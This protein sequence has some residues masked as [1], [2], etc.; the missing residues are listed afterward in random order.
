M[1][2]SFSTLHSAGLALIL[3]GAVAAVHEVVAELL[4]APPAVAPGDDFFAYANREWLAGA[5]LPTGKGRWGARDEIAEATRQQVQ[6]V[7][8][9]SG[10]SP[11]AIRVADFH[12]AWQDEAAIEAKGAAA[13][14]ASFAEIDSI[15]SVSGLSRYLGAHLPADVD[16][17]GVGTYDSAHPIGLSVSYGLHGER[18]YQPYLTQGGLG[19]RD[20]EAY[21]GDGVERQVALRAYRQYV[22][23]M[24]SYAGFDEP[25]RRARAVVALETAMARSHAPA[26][27]SAKETNA[28]H[29]WGRGDFGL[30]ARGLDWKAFFAA[31][32]LSK[33]RDFIVWQPGAIKGTSALVASQPLAAWK[34]YLRFHLLDREADVLPHRFA[35]AARAFREGPASRRQRALEAT[36]RLL[37]ED[38]G[39]LYAEHFFPPER[40]ARVEAILHHVVGAAKARVAQAE[41]M[42]VAARTEALEKLEAMYFGV[43]YPDAWPVI[44]GLVIDPR[45]ALGNVRRI[46][47]WRYDAALAKLGQDVDRREWAIPWHQPGAILNFQLNAYNFAAALLQAPKFDPEASEAAN[48]GAIG[49]IFAHEITHFVDSLGA[50][51]DGQGDARNWWMDEDRSRYEAR[52]R[53]LVEQFAAYQ[54]LPWANVDGRRTLVENYADLSGLVL[55]FEAHRAALGPGLDAATVRARD[56]EFFVG[57]AKSWRATM[58]EDAL[59]NWLKADSHAPDRF[60]VAT[61]RNLDAWYDAFDVKPGQA[62]WLAPGERVRIW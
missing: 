43:A 9:L 13:L 37:P 17:M 51:Y 53:A 54:P 45:D 2:K 40:K 14:Q 24:L 57:Y 27:E 23:L 6:Q 60:R 22:A 44:S 16:P 28:D 15:D 41:W 21:L 5:S 62:L 49:A 36:S 47:R 50:A 38:V 39:R 46:G 56:R 59:R 4:P 26:A 48:Y 61:V 10:T 18:T 35:A 20:R 32:G 7:V 34:D 58:N 3:V 31:A 12:A 1:S 55:A 29:Y 33:Q 11:H 52:S 42:T 30:E 8:R 25:M 19:L